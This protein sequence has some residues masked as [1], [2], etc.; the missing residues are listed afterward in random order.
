MFVL[1]ATDGP[2]GHVVDLRSGEA[3]LSTR[4]EEVASSIVAVSFSADGNTAALMTVGG[5][6]ILYSVGK[7]PRTLPAGR[8][9][10]GVSFVSGSQLL[11][12]NLRVW[13]LRGEPKPIATLGG[14]FAAI[15]DSA[16]VPG[17]LAAAANEDTTIRLYDAETW[18]PEREIRSSHTTPRAI[19]FSL[20]GRQLFVG[21]VDRLVKRYDPQS[22]LQLGSLKPAGFVTDLLTLP[23]GKSLAVQTEGTV[24]VPPATWEII[25][26]ESGVS[27]PCA[28]DRAADGL[29]VVDGEIWCVSVQGDTVDTWTVP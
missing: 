14:D 11:A 22:G 20:D 16:L 8:P 12:M 15:R 10:Q 3:L 24:A 17:G 6:A 2:S 9:G 5:E 18:Q 21:G 1:C 7:P 4:L 25:D 27:R 26:I 19:A 28:P 29:A 13:D 23:D